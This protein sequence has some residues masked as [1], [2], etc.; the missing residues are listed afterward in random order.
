MNIPVQMLD[1]IE[2]RLIAVLDAGSIL[3]MAGLVAI[4]SYSI[5]ARQILMTPASWAQEVAAGL[6]VWMVSCG[7]AVAWSRGAHIVVDTFTAALPQRLKGSAFRIIQMICFVFFLVTVIGS[8]RMMLKS[9]YSVTGALRISYSYLYLA[10]FIGGLAMMFV[11]L[12]N[13]IR[14]GP[15]AEPNAGLGA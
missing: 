12:A 6:A 15:I 11:S 2:R 9:G 3:M 8:Y 13:V 10:I 14:G 1:A 4:V 7:A 5:L